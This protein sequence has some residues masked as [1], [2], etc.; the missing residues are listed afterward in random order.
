MRGRETVVPCPYCCAEL[1]DRVLWDDMRQMPICPDCR[2]CVGDGCPCEEATEHTG[3]YKGWP[4]APEL[5]VLTPELAAALDALLDVADEIS[6]GDTLRT[7]I[8]ECVD[9]V[10]RL[11]DFHRVRLGGKERR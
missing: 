5:I 7:N 3:T 4:S 8:G 1:Y 6:G 9:R 2:R 11:H 10:L